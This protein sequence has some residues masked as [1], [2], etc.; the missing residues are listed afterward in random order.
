MSSG[1]LDFISLSPFSQVSVT[2]NLIKTKLLDEF[3]PDCKNHEE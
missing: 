2:V 3:E 1:Y